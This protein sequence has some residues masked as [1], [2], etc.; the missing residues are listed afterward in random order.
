MGREASARGGC[1]EQGS[2]QQR[3]HA[4]TSEGIAALKVQPMILQACICDCR[5]TSRCM[6]RSFHEKH[7]HK[8][9]VLAIRSSCAHTLVNW[10]WQALALDDPRSCLHAWQVS[11]L[12]TILIYADT[13]RA[14]LQSGGCLMMWSSLKSCLTQPRARFPSCNCVS[15]CRSLGLQVRAAQ[16][17]DQQ[18][19]LKIKNISSKE[20]KYRA[21]SHTDKYVLPTR[22]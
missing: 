14:S 2:S 11:C 1:K 9:H 22:L 10:Q 7:D 3:S 6:C 15:N 8:T 17:C 16:S 13:C 21:Y 18:S 20:R 5:Y 12:S 4:Q 19:W